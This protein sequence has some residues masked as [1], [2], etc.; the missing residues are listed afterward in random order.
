MT[1]DTNT[2]QKDITV[3]AGDI[4]PVTDND[5]NFGTVTIEQGGQLAIQTAAQVIIE[6]LVKQ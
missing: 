3:K 2:E 1:N 5:R 4:Y 6:H